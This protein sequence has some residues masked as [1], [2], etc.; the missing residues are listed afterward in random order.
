MKYKIVFLICILFS[1][2]K[3]RDD[4]YTWN[5]VEVN[6]TA[7]NSLKYQTDDYPNITAFGDTLKP[8]MKCIAVSRDLIAKGLK[9]NTPVKIQGFEGLYFVK[10]K[11]HS[12][13]KNKI[14]IYMGEDVK[15]AKEWGRRKIT[16]EYGL[17]KETKNKN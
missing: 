5:S 1:C 8:E 16:I 17:P 4:F 2:K 11:M 10:D 9:H 12:K 14:D 13:W 15:A 6:A 7:Y 3:Y